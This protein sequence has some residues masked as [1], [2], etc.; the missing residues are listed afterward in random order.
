MALVSAVAFGSLSILAK[1]A[2]ASGLGTSQ[3]LAFR[4]VLAA[5]G[6]LALSLVA[7]QSP[8]RLPRRRILTLFAVGAVIYTGQSLAY[9]TALR[10]L[11]ASLC[12][13]IV[14]M[15]PSLVVLAAWLF[16]RRAVSRWHLL[17]LLA[18]FAGLVLL[19]GG[20]ELRLSWALLL[21]VSAAVIYTAYIMVGERVMAGTPAL[22]A[23]ALI[24]SGAALSFCILAGG[25]GQLSPPAT[26]HQWAAGVAIA[27]V[28]TMV[29]VS[30]FMAA[31]PRI[32]GARAALLSTLE[33]VITV[34]LA[35]VLLGD[36]LAAVQVL[37]GGL[38]LAA[39]VFVQTA[40]LWSPKAPLR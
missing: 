38:V 18:S 40:H 33:P 32:G 21:A 19:V 17:A 23:N 4:F 31:L 36:R 34:V 26:A 9:F 6:M 10:S 16:Q 15:Y 28:P 14:Y 12:V 39:V 1:F 29:A 37:G 35:V 11:P 24:M 5:G 2:Y 22:P 30:L 27:V 7:R 13:L 25:G 3:L 8:T 20:A